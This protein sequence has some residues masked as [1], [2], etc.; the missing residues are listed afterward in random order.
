M[1]KI[2]GGKSYDTETSEKLAECQ[3][4][5]RRDFYFVCETLYRKRN[6]AYFLHGE[7]GAASRYAVQID[8]NSTGPGERITP[9]SIKEAQEWTEKYC[10]GDVYEAIFGAVDDDRIQISLWISKPDKDAAEDLKAKKKVTYADIYAAG[11][12]ALMADANLP[13]VENE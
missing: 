5:N 12:K 8:Q 2:I 13:D 4:S 1:K 3:Y 6:G 11:I 9:L 10:D 7:G